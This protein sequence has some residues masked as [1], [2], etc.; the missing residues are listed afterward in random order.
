MAEAPGTLSI[1]VGGQLEIG[2]P[3]HVFGEPASQIVN[4]GTLTK[5]GAGESVIQATVDLVNNATLEVHGGTLSLDGTTTSTGSVAVAAGATLALDGTATFAAASVFN[6]DGTLHVHGGTTTIEGSRD[7]AAVIIESG[8][9]VVG[10]GS[11]IGSLTVNGTAQ[12]TGDT[13][14]GV[15]ALNGHKLTVDGDLAVTDDFVPEGG[16]IDLA[17]GSFVDLSPGSGAAIV[18]GSAATDTVIGTAFADVLIGHAGNDI[19]TGG[20]GADRIAY[21]SPGDG[22]DSLIDFA[23]SDDVL[24][25]DATVFG[26][27]LL[28]GQ[29]LS[30]DQ[31]VS[32]NPPQPSHA[33]GQFLYD[34][35]LGDLYWDGDGTGDVHAPVLMATLQG[36][37]ALTES[38]FELVDTAG[39]MAMSEVATAVDG[40]SDPGV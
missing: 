31:F 12:I 21:G 10:D 40:G 7:I 13:S 16:V 33:H 32:G 20:T 34:S 3:V 17:S 2:G 23:V 36:A 25:I 35:I 9:L 28:A 18:D 5:T 24:V 39:F 4:D 29:P 14:V 15:L 11:I 27:G 1:G 6:V 8:T 30:A 19:L 22:A 26:G 37:P 38:D